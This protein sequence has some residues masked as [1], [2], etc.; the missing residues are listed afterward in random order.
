MARQ[1]VELGYRGLGDTIRREDFEARKRLL[2]ERSTLKHAAPRQLA[3]IDKHLSN[4]PFLEALA[5]REELIRTGKLTTIAFIRD[6]NAK[7]QEISGYV[8]IAHRLRTED[9]NPI[10]DLK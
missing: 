2:L 5:N 1:L 6:Y 10:F 8:D 7:G 3:S 4:H 9:F